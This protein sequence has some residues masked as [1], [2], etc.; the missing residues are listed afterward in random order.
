MSFLYLSHLFSSLFVLFLFKTQL[1]QPA[2][3]PTATVDIKP[4]NE[5][6]TFNSASNSLSNST[7]QYNVLSNYNVPSFDDRCI[8]T[9]ELRLCEFT[10]F[11]EIGSGAQATKH[12]FVQIGG[13]SSCSDPILED[14]DIRQISDKFPQNKEGLK[15]LYD[16]GPQNAFFLV[17]FWVSNSANLMVPLIF[18]STS[19]WSWDESSIS[20]WKFSHMTLLLDLAL[21]VFFFLCFIG[22][23][24]KVFTNICYLFYLVWISIAY[25]FLVD[26][27][28]SCDISLSIF[29][30]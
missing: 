12:I 14:I 26:Q 22:N 13:P 18:P 23:K 27:A 8:A 17:K 6:K 9:H 16:K 21:A 20:I 19:H 3:G 11:L 1:W 15:E 2:V 30:C 25:S 4:F 29:F 28:I 7:L 24:L 10:A 5:L